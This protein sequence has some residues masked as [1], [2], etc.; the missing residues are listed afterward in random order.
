LAAPRLLDQ[1][2]FMSD[3]VLACAA[4]ETV[5]DTSQAAVSTKGRVFIRSSS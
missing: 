4:V 2:A 1:K 3:C 5:N